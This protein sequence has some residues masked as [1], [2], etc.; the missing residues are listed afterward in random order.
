MVPQNWHFQTDLEQP[1]IVVLTQSGVK[2]SGVQGTNI[3]IK[4]NLPMTRRV[5]W[6]TTRLLPLKLFWG[7]IWGKLGE[8]RGILW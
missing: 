4:S 2:N 7:Q 6:Y 1:Q 8:N 3:N 5:V